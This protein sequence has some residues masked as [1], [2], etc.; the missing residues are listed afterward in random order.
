[1]HSYSFENKKHFVLDD[2][3][4]NVMSF[5]IAEE[6]LKLKDG[7]VLKE[8][9]PPFWFSGLMDFLLNDINLTLIYHDMGGTELILHDELVKEGNLEYV[10]KLSKEIYNYIHQ[11]ESPI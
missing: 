2:N 10:Q 7:F 5:T 3:S 4:D 6:F 11:N 9:K 1:M 8:Y